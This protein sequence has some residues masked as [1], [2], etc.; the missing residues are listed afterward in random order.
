VTFGGVR[1]QA[2]KM[3]G[4]RKCGRLPRGKDY[5]NGKTRNAFSSS[6]QKGPSFSS[7]GRGFISEGQNERK[8]KRFEGAL[9]AS[10]DAAG[11]SVIDTEGEGPGEPRKPEEGIGKKQKKEKTKGTVHRLDCDRFGGQ[12]TGCKKGRGCYQNCNSKTATEEGGVNGMRKGTGFL[13]KEKSRILRSLDRQKD[14][15]KKDEGQKSQ[16][17]VQT[18][19]ELKIK[20]LGKEAILGKVLL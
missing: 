5:D 18:S 19:V 16:Q 15:D 9:K 3:G 13:C 8:R 20:Q 7:E 1:K 6:N 11:L 4:K 2:K 12:G 14:R 17:L 10:A